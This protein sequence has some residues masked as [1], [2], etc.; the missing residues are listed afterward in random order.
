MKRIASIDIARGLVMV[1]MALDHTR[2]LLDAWS[3]AH[4]PT[5]LTVTTPL[6]FFTRWITHFCAPAFVFLSGASA[7]IQLTRSTNPRE[8]RRWL[9]RRGLILIAVEYTIVNFGISFDF[10]FRLLLFEVIGTI[11]AGMILLSPV[12]RLPMRWLVPIT[13][14]ILF[15]H[16]LLPLPPSMAMAA[17][18]SSPAFNVLRTFG[19][20]PGSF[21]PGPNLLIAVAYPIIP[22]FGIMLAGFV[23]GRWFQR[24][25]AER[26]R[27][28]LAAGGITLGLFVVLRFINGYGDFNPW[29]VQKNT[30]FTAL[31]FLNVDKYPPTLLFC[32]LTL[33][34]LFL[35]LAAAEPRAPQ[36][37]APIPPVIVQPA[38]QATQPSIAVQPATQ[39]PAN[40]I[41]RILLVYGRV[42]LFYFI[43]HFYLIHLLMLVVGF[44]QGYSLSQLNFGPFQFGRPATGGGLPTWCIY[45]IWIAV[46][47]VMYPLCRCYG[48]F[49]FSHPE[50]KFLRYF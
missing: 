9:L 32:L 36:Q 27:L 13:A 43:V 28:F 46:V 4:T 24:P 35:I 16:D 2:E 7:A 37:P 50:K 5:D 29:S 23:T 21:Q 15:G 38:T 47:A 14:L 3:R 40:A 44:A 34:G 39:P 41:T 26:K 48:Q 18:N 1:I 17:P 33:G 11:G 30:L 6:L 20:S 25:A 42:P 19:W 8:T 49:K 45:P 12:S 10:R 22:W 31:S